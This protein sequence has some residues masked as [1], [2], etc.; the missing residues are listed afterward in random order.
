MG[1][2]H[3]AVSGSSVT[4]GLRTGR[5]EVTVLVCMARPVPHPLT[6]GL[7]GQWSLRTWDFP[8][9]VTLG[10]EM[11]LS[12]DTFS[13]HL[14]GEIRA[15]M[16]MHGTTPAPGLLSYADL[17]FSINLNYRCIPQRWIWAYCPLLCVSVPSASTLNKSLFSAS[18]R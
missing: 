14:E 5:E 8:R 6:T 17:L 13:D 1:K 11:S 2:P 9:R 16:M 12:S 7:L 4:P 10:E 15:E 3:R 18:H